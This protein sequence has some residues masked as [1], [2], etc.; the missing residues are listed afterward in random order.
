MP[1]PSLLPALILH[2]PAKDN[3]SS[4]YYASVL[5]FID[6]SNVG[7]RTRAKEKLATETLL[8]QAALI[9]HEIS[10]QKDH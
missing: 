2:S 7:L 3:H 9:A 1:S 8:K 10:L 6:P 5:R 4:E